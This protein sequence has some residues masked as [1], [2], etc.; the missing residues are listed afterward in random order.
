MNKANILHFACLAVLIISLFALPASAEESGE[1]E[2]PG[3][4]ARVFAEAEAELGGLDAENTLIITDLGS[5]AG[6]YIFQDAF[7]KEFFEKGF[8][9]TRNLINVQNTRNSPLWFAFFDK[10]SGNCTF[11]EIKGL[12][13]PEL[14][15]PVT[16]NIGFEKLYSDQAA[17]SEEVNRKVFLGREFAIVTIANGWAEGLDYELVQCL[18]LHNH[19]CP[20]VSSGYV[21]AKWMEENYPLEAGEQ[22]VVF[23]CPT[24]CKEDVFVRLWD[25]TPGKRGLWVSDLSVEEKEALGAPAGIFVVWN[26]AEGTGKAVALNFDFDMV[27]AEC[28][29][30]EGDAGWASKYLMDVWMLDENNWEGLV[31]EI[32]VI[33]IDEATLNE[34][35]LA[36]S[37][38]YVTLGLLKPAGKS[39]PSENASPGIFGWMN[40]IRGN[41]VG[42]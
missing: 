37:N 13:S 34:M 15:P 18:E 31:S 40:K 23:S 41:G 5:P 33:D 11:I 30:K 4:M 17:W 25:A 38:P 19:F 3:I 28:G 10:A 12:T 39:N 20:G 36:D 29:S 2:T 16:R 7:Y 35:K 14:V 24:W 32:A 1:I 21:L 6:S 42:N 26:G 22:Y 27:R 8:S 9:S